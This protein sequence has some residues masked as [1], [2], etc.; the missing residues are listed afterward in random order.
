[1]LLIALQPRLGETQSIPTPAFIQQALADNLDGLAAYP[2]TAGSDALRALS[3][4]GWSSMAHVK[5]C[6]H[7]RKP[8]SIRASKRW[9][10][11]PNPLYQIYE[12]AAYLAGAEPYFVNCDPAR[13]FAPDFA[14]ITPEV[15]GHVCNCLHLLAKVNP[16]GAVLTPGRIG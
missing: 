9:S 5:P 2:T 3:R 4:A 16:L 15:W 1:M 13:N 6:L 14:S 12:G 11:C 8:S 10:F 7:W